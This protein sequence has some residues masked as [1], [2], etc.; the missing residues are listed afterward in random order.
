MA[1]TPATAAAEKKRKA[2]NISESSSAVKDEMD[3]II[4]DENTRAE[5]M[6]EILSQ[7]RENCQSFIS[8]ANE[9]AVHIESERKTMKLEL[10]NWEEEK[11]RIAS[12]HNFKPKVK[13]DV[14]G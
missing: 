5:K 8:K 4:E 13:L 9:E 3:V 11:K 6:E 14:G 10:A 7:V 1:K 12:T 2:S